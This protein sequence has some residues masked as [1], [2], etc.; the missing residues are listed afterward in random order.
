M[1]IRLPNLAAAVLLVTAGMFAS[2]VLAADSRDKLPKAKPA[3]GGE[4]KANP[5]PV[6]EKPAKVTDDFK[7]RDNNGVDD[8]HEKRA[9]RSE[10][11][12]APTVKQ[13]PKPEA[14][15]EAR[16]VEPKATP[17]AGKPAEPPPK[18]PPRR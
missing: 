10:P 4:A 12:A 17:P 6:P 5:Q 14:A 16:P 3:Q 15:R 9:I 8:R 7:D 11:A 1:K 13:D 18:A 2:E